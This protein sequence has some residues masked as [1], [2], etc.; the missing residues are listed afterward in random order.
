[1]YRFL[2]FFVLCA[3]TTCAVFANDHETT[4]RFSFLYSVNNAGYIDVCGCKHKEV[5]QGGLAR[6]FT[7]VKQLQALQ[8]PHVLLDGGCLLFD[9]RNQTVKGF[10]RKQVIAKARIIIEGYN[11]M[12]Y[13]A[14][15]LGSSDLYL[16]LDVLKELLAEARFPMLCANF[17]GPDKKPVFKPWTIV[18]AGGVRIGVVGLIM[19]TLNPHFIEKVA[20]G[21]SVED[22]VE[23]ARKAVSELKPKCEFI[24]ALSHARQEE[25]TQLAKKVPE[26]SI[27]F[28]PNIT[29]GSHSL[30]INNAEEYYDTVNKKL[31]VRSDGEGM[32]L[33]KVDV[34]FS[35]PFGGI[36]T[37]AELNR[38]EKGIHVKVVPEDFSSVLGTGSFNGAAI[39]RISIEPH[40]LPEPGIKHLVDLWKQ[41]DPGKLSAEALKEFEAK[42]ARFNGAE[43]CKSCHKEQYDFW[44]KTDHA[45]AYRAL[46]ENSDHLRYDCIGCHTVGFGYAFVHPKNV[47]SFKNVQCESCHG[48][49]PDHVAD[50]EKHPHWPRISDQ[51]CLKCHNKE[52]LRVDFNVRAKTPLVQCPKMK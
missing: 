17:L 18:T 40:Y 36:K 2:A 51:S 10:E 20:P 14:A 32:R 31:I 7:L 47:G 34:D 50:P 25:N 27:I 16:G 19:N 11:R 43:S 41:K 8:R 12:G 37:S 15:A 33:M 52:Q 38:L 21:C 23:S 30:F 45:D 39:S 4:K 28:D 5:K 3:T 22:L 46:E 42:P 44:K 29:Y 13:R 24:V 1:M 6:R 9:L 35:V 26:I 48:A 49:N